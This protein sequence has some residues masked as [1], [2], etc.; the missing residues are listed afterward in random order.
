[1]IR[2]I[3]IFTAAT[4]RAAMI[5]FHK[6]MCLLAALGLSNADY[7]FCILIKLPSIKITI[8]ISMKV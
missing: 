6:V 5:D 7:I 8:W 2:K 3:G 4:V 1:M